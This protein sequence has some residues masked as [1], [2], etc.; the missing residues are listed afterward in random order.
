M[1]ACYQDIALNPA[2]CIALSCVSS[3]VTVI[4]HKYFITAS[5]TDSESMF[6]TMMKN[7]SKI[8]FRILFAFISSIIASI[9]VASRNG[10]TPELLASSYSKIAG[11]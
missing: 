5:E 2:A 4:V 11:F 6:K 7:Y 3:I 10:T 9:V 8:V 1:I